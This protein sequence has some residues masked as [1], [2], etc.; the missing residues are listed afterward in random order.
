MT[1]TCTACLLTPFNN[2]PDVTTDTSTSSETIQGPSSLHAT[3]S[4]NTQE[5]T[6]RLTEQ[7]TQQATPR[8]YTDLHNHQALQRAQRNEQNKGSNSCEGSLPKCRLLAVL[9]MIKPPSNV[10]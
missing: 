5:T 6:T 10:A 2:L 8:V 3:C 1:F 4:G 9:G 7:Q